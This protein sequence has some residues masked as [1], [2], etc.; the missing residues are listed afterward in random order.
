MGVLSEL[1]QYLKKP[2]SLVEEVLSSREHLFEI[3]YDIWRSINPDAHLLEFYM[4][5]TLSMIS[6]AQDEI[7][8]DLDTDWS[9]M[10]ESIPHQV[11]SVFD[12]G[13]GIG[14]AGL[15]F[16]E[17]TPGASLSFF[18]PN[19]FAA[20]FL[21]WRAYQRKIEVIEEQILST[22]IKYDL[23]ICWGVFEHLADITA[24]A[25]AAYL[26]ES[27]TDRGKLFVKNFYEQTDAYL[28]HFPKGPRMAKFY[29]RFEDK[30]IFAKHS[31]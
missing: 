14:S 1:A 17:R 20:Q 27:L 23:I 28:L 9:D 26:V 6:N 5:S 30:I 13:A 11:T 24:E 22:R 7:E 18:E 19:R 31:H 4:N 10:M 21:K 29:E 15:N 25:T 3:E 16:V 2:E 12:Y 8:R